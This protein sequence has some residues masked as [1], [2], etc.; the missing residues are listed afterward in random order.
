[1]KRIML[2]IAV[3]LFAVAAIDA[4]WLPRDCVYNP[5]GTPRNFTNTVYPCCPPF[6]NSICGSALG[7]GYCAPV[8]ACT[9]GIAADD[10]DNAFF[11]NYKC[12]CYG[13]F[14][15]YNC[16]DCMPGWR[17]PKCDQWYQITIRN[18][19]TFT[20]LEWQAFHAMM[21][22]CNTLIDNIFVMARIGNR[23]DRRTIGFFNISFY[24][25]CIANHYHATKAFANNGRESFYP[26]WAHAGAG[27]L[28]WHRF[29]MIMCNKQLQRCMKNEYAHLPYYKWEDD[30]GCAVCQEMGAHGIDGRLS[31]FSIYY[32]WGVC[33]SRKG[34]L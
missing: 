10:R 7:R 1:M 20:P 25:L 16:G 19:Q 12:E 18:M 32:H 28:P 11:F 30:S 4:W 14:W 3:L 5:D 9:P 23:F 34:V 33:T 22:Y 15:G 6:Q 29:W 27:F 24:G 2:S 17:G 31:V 21:H 13:N 26:G 8:N